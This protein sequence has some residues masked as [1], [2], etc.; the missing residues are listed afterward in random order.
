MDEAASLIAEWEDLLARRPTFRDS[1]GFYGS[2][3]DAW[4]GWSPAG[5]PVLRWRPGEC[6]ER[7]ARG[8]S[9]IAEAP[10][11]FDREALEP[12]FAPLVE[13]LAALRD[14]ATDPLRRFAAAWDEGQ[15]PPSDLLPARQKEGVGALWELLEI[16][17]DL[18]SLLTY[19]GL[20]PPLEAYFAEA[21]TAFSPSLWDAG[22]CPFCGGAP[23][24]EDI[25]EDG[26]RW[27]CCALCGG[28]WT[29]GRLRC[30][31]CDNRD[32]K[33]LT[34]LAA[35]DQEEGYLVEACDLCRRYLKGV[36]RR[37][38][39]NAASGLIEDWGTPHLDLIA[40]R[41]G[42]RRDTTTLI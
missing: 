30:P 23:S 26:K 39:W 41:R 3:L 42:Y 10:P 31:F 7:W 15:F 8:I 34:R 17:P 40:R 21:R 27:L 13:G 19:L 24:F 28:R 36:D 29:T 5:C 1:L 2:V 4:G 35:E 6:R 14:N 32:A 37:V 25:A 9:L 20:R 22:R 38:R 16:P 12:L 33:T 11:T 18:L